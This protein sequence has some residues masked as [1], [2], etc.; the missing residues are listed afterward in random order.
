MH[1]YGKSY[2]ERQARKST[3]KRIKQA[4]NKQTNKHTIQL[5]QK[6]YVHPLVMS[7]VCAMLLFCFVSGCSERRTERMSKYGSAGGVTRASGERR[8]QERRAPQVELLGPP[9]AADRDVPQG[10]VIYIYIYI[11]LLLFIVFVCLLACLFVC[12]LA[13]LL[14]CLFVCCFCFPCFAYLVEVEF[15]GSFVLFVCLLVCFVLVV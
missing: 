6:L 7:T 14:A 13:C 11:M 1:T 4:A 10:A 3:K 15:V 5:P 9:D 12:L 2:K 8:G